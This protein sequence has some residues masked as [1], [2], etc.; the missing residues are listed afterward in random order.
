MFEARTY[1]LPFGYPDRSTRC[2]N[3]GNP[4]Q[5]NT[6]TNQS[7]A[8]QHACRSMT[9]SKSHHVKTFSGRLLS[10]FAATAAIV[11]HRVLVAVRMTEMS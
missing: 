11:V 9:Q 8:L 6:T 10:G 3:L 1:P 7:V 5:G 2:P 4:H